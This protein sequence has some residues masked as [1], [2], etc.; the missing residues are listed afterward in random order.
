MKN[1]SKERDVNLYETLINKVSMISGLCPKRGLNYHR[2]QQYVLF[3]KGEISILLKSIKESMENYSERLEDDWI[4]KN[5]Y[6]LM[7]NLSLN[8]FS[9][10]VRKNNTLLIRR[11]KHTVFFLL[12][13]YINKKL[14]ICK[15]LDSLIFEKSNIIH[16]LD[17]ITYIIEQLA[18]NQYKYLRY[19]FGE[20]DLLVDILNTIEC[21][22]YPFTVFDFELYILDNI[23]IDLPVGFKN[24]MES[25]IDGMLIRYQTDKYNVTIIESLRDQFIVDKNLY[26]FYINKYIKYK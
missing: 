4:L 1:T 2:S 26:P 10:K 3:I 25:L 23:E 24:M 17:T 12:K 20:K 11:V 6:S 18:V 9:E 19:S 15:D 14:N 13:N 21:D 16:K 7:D 5:R 22:I 8:I